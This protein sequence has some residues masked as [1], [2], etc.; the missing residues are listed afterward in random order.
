MEAQIIADAL[1][2]ELSLRKTCMLTNQHHEDMG[3][4]SLTL[5]FV[6]TVVKALKPKID[7]VTK[8]KE[9]SMDI[10]DSRSISRYIWS[11]YLLIFL[12]F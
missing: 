8:Q 5:S 2:G 10:N 7:S 9:G 6:Y 1:E 12:V 4:D 11:T 3:L